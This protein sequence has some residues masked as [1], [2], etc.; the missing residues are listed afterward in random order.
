MSESRKN[1]VMQINMHPNDARHVVHTLP[2]Q[3]RMWGRQVDR[4]VVTLDLH[5]SRAG[6][7]RNDAFGQNLKAITSALGKIARS[8]PIEVVE[9][10]YAPDVRDDVSRQFFASGGI[11]DKAWD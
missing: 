7:Y 4:V 8:S 10:N 5:R 9:V 1:V 6:R 3:I 11:P 2:H